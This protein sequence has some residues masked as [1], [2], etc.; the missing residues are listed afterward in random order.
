MTRANRSAS[1]TF[2]YCAE[3]VRKLREARGWS[4][5]ELGR[6]AGYT[7]A[8]ISALETL[9]QPPTEVMLA[10]LDQVFFDG[11]GIFTL[12]GKFLALDHLPS[13]FKDYALIE[14]DALTISS[15]QPF[16]M[17]GVFQTEQYA[18]AIIGGAY[19]ALTEEEINAYVNG[20]LAR[21]AL[22]DRK[23]PIPHI[24]LILEEA[25]LRR[26]FGTREAMALQLL[27]LLE[28]SKRPNVCVQILRMDQGQTGEHAG[29]DGPMKLLEKSDHKQVVYLEVQRRGLLISQPEEV[30]EMAQRHMMLRAQALNRY[31]SRNFIEKVAAE[32]Q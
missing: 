4:Q 27:H 16:T 14:Q 17:D 31:E 5:E 9:K 21:A 12:A 13:F 2:Q 23:N 19:P 10:K 18:R 26:Q 11:Q 29:V 25:V 1:P 15:Y 22:F 7:G 20:R 3:M 28:L 30:S 8:A 24:D 32:W 6:R